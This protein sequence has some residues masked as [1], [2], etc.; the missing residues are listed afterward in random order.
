M[1]QLEQPLAEKH[2]KKEHW[3]L[4]SSLACVGA[5]PGTKADV[6]VPVTITDVEIGG[7]YNHCNY[8]VGTRNCP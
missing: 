1:E 2:L 7:S 3:T 5:N 8:R 6:F 4:D